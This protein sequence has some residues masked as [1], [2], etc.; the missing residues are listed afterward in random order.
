[1]TVIAPPMRV[2]IC[3]KGISCSR[4][5]AVG[6]MLK[7]NGEYTKASNVRYLFIAV[8]ILGSIFGMDR[9]VLVKSFL[10]IF[11]PHAAGTVAATVGT[12]IGVAL[13]LGAYQTFFFIVIPIMA[14][15]VGEGAIPL[16]IGYSEILHQEQGGL[17][18]HVLPPIMLGSMTAIAQ[19]AA[20]SRW[21][22]VRLI[23]SQPVSVMIAVSPTDMLNP[24][25]L[26]S[27]IMCRKKTVRGGD[28]ELHLI[29]WRDR[30]RGRRGSGRVVPPRRRPSASGWRSGRRRRA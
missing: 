16:S 7:P 5:A 6:A 27:K 26:L 15:G 13:G 9:Q 21:R 22:G 3:A 2:A 10:K 29:S 23:G 20:T 1:M 17:F 14:G 19:P 4:L 30:G 28:L 24:V 11:V 8:I 18:P 25:S 12:L